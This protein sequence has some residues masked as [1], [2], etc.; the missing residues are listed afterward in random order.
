M[1]SLVSGWGHGWH[2]MK[3]VKRVYTVQGR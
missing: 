3:D 1:T 2:D